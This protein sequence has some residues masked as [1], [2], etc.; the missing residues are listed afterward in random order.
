MLMEETAN[1]RP[2][3]VEGRQKLVDRSC[4]CRFEM[5]VFSLFSRK[6]WKFHKITSPI[7][8]ERFESRRGT[9]INIPR[10][11]VVV[12]MPLSG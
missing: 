8:S 6:D 12:Q 2:P 5:S 9:V 10:P 7:R 4:R 11:R 1:A 3:D